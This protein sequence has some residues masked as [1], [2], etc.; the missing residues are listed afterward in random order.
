MFT[1]TITPERIASSVIA[2][3]PLARDSGLAVNR[4][5]NLKLIRHIESG[6]VRTLLYGG[7]ANF[8]NTSLGEYEELLG[9]LAESVGDDTW[10]IPSVGPA[11]GTM[12]EQ[13]AIL[14][15][16]AFPT[17]MVLPPASAFSPEGVESGFR[18]FVESYGRPAVLYIKSEGVI[19]VQQVK[20]L[21]DDGLVAW[22]KYAI[23]RE[24]PLIDDYL[25]QLVDAVDKRFVVSGIGEQPAIAHLG[26]FGVGGFTSGCVCLAPRLSMELRA[27]IA[28]GDVDRCERIRSTF[29]PLED[30]RNADNPIRVLHDAVTLSGIADMGPILPLLANLAGDQRVTVKAAARQLLEQAAD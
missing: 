14:R 19:E 10:L 13:A 7:N 21:F 11:F 8:Y 15:N 24:D 20:R 25:R 17:A 2:V 29:Q 9:F 16:H 22:V 4:Q 1:N 27:A 28:M 30:L 3:P 12:M 26:K 23:V 6:G 18:H 5:E